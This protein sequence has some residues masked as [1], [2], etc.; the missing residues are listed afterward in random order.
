MPAKIFPQNIIINNLHIKFAN[1]IE[2][3]DKKD[4]EDNDVTSNFII[5]I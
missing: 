2:N 3:E 1:E 4:R 5:F